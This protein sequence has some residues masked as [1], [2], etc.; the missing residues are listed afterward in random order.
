MYICVIYV[1]KTWTTGQQG[2]VHVHPYIVENPTAPARTAE[3]MHRVARAAA[4]T[5]T[6]VSCNN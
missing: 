1:G 3:E 6:S 4:S 2:G 5:H